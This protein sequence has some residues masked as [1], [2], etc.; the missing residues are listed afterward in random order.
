MYLYMCIYHIRIH[1]GWLEVLENRF[2]TRTLSLAFLFSVL[3]FSFLH[4]FSFSVVCS[5]FLGSSTAV[6]RPTTTATTTTTM[7]IK[8]KGFLLSVGCV[9]LLH[10]EGYYTI[11]FRCGGISQKTTPFQTNYCTSN[12]AS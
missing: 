6:V 8:G 11:S 4:F 3:L 9:Y 12:A 7:I 10:G 5:M 1:Y 2:C